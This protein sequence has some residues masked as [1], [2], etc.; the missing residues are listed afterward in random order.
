MRL[1][2]P[3]TGCAVDAPEGVA[4]RLVGQGFRPAEEE[5]PK[6]PAPKRRAAK[7]PAKTE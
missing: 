2:N 7:K 1:V 3:Y 6:R 4:E 5:A